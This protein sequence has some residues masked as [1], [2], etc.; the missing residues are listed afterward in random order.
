MHDSCFVLHTVNL[1]PSLLKEPQK[2]DECKKMIV[3][4]KLFMWPMY[5]DQR[6]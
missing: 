2:V 4:G 5:R 6:K 3:A 1:Y